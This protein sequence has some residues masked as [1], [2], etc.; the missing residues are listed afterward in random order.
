MKEYNGNE[1]GVVSHEHHNNEHFS[2]RIYIKRKDELKELNDL[3]Q[4]EMALLKMGVRLSIGPSRY[5]DSR[6]FL[7]CVI[8][9]SI[10]RNIASRGAGRHAEASG[11]NLEDVENM[12]AVG[13]SPQE[14]AENAHM[15]LATYYRRR[16]KALSL[17]NKGFLPSDIPF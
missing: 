9:V 16:K 10:D 6:N 17:L 2:A 14:I 13:I 7:A 12:L 8:N 5:Q 11:L 1:N 3:H 4:A 15:S